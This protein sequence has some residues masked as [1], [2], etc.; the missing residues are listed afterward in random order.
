[1][2]FLD[3]VENLGNKSTTGWQVLPSPDTRKCENPPI[4][5]VS[6]PKKT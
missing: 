2:L 5:G 3:Q 4:I 1:M 6:S